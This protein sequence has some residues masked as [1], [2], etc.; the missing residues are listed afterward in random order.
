M[1]DEKR[2]ISRYRKVAGDCSFFSGKVVWG[3][4][5]SIFGIG[6]IIRMLMNMRVDGKEKI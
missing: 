6:G 3:L 4:L 2:V 5:L 1:R